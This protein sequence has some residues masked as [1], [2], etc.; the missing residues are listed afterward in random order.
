MATTALAWNFNIPYRTQQI[1]QSNQVKKE[2]VTFQ[3]N[4]I[5]II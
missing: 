5:P 1:F 4:H 3:S 2:I